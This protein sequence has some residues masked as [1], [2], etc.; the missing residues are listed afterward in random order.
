MKYSNIVTL[1]LSWII[2]IMTP[3]TATAQHFRHLGLNNGLSQPSVMCISQ[4]QLGRMWFGTREGIN[5]YDGATMQSFKGWV[6]DPVTG[7][8][9]WIGNNVESIVP[10]SMN[11]MVILIDKNIVK[12]E[13][14]SDRFIPVVSIGEV[15]ALAHFNGELSYLSN[16]S[17]YR[18]YTDGRHEFLFKTPRFNKVNDL[19][20]SGDKFFV[21]A[22]TGLWAFDKNSGHPTA[23]L[24]GM[25]V[26]SSFLSK[27]G[28]L[29]ICT[30]SNGVMCLRPDEQKPVLVSLPTPMKGAMGAHQTRRAVEDSFG[31]IWYGTFSGLHCYDPVT[32]TTKLIEAPHNLSGLSHSSIFGLYHDKDGTIWA[33]SYYGGVNYFNPGYD[34]YFNFDYTGVATNGLYHSLIIDMVYD[35]SGNLWMGTDGGG[36][37]CVNPEWR[38]L[39]QLN[40]M[41]GTNALRQNNIKALEYDPRHNRVY[42]GTHLGGLSYFDISSGRTVNLIDNHPSTALLG[43]VIQ[44]MKYHN[45]ALYVSSRKGITRLDTDTGATS[46]LSKDV[47][48]KFTIDSDG[49]LW[50]INNLHLTA[51]NVDGRQRPTL[52]NAIHQT[53]VDNATDIISTSHGITVGSRGKGLVH[54]DLTTGTARR[55]TT[56]NSPLP[57]DY[58]YTLSADSVGNIYIATDGDITKWNPADNTMRSISFD[59]FF[60]ESN[61]IEECGL[62]ARRDGSV[63]VGSTRGITVLFDKVFR[64]NQSTAT[65]STPTMFFTNLVVGSNEVRPNDGSGILSEALPYAKT[66]RLPHD[67][68]NFSV[69]VAQPDFSSAAAGGER[70]Q[71]RLDGIDKEWQT[72][73]GNNIHYT[74]LTPG[75]YT[76]YARPVSPAGEPGATT[77]ELK[78]KVSHAW[79]ASVWAWIVY[80]VIIVGIGSYIFRR[81]QIIARLRQSLHKEQLE[82]QQIEKL[83]QEKLVFFTNVSHEF[84]TPLTLI[85]SH[86]DMLLAKGGR[87]TPF[88]TQLSRIRAHAEQMS[89]LVTQLLEFRKFQSDS[90]VMRIGLHDAGALLNEVASPFLDYAQRRGIRFEVVVPDPSPRGCFDPQLLNRVLVNILSNA[91]KYTPDGGHIECSVTAIDGKVRFSF[92]DNGRGIPEEEIP[93]VFDRFYNGSADEINQKDLDFKSTGI[94]LAFAKSIV[95]KHHGTITVQSTEN[96]GSTFTVE[97]PTSREPFAN[98]PQVL[99]DD[100]ATTVTTTTD[101]LQIRLANTEE[102]VTPDDSPTPNKPLILIAEDNDELREQLSIFFGAYYRVMQAADGAEAISMAR[103]CNPDLI[104]SDVLM[105]NMN[106]VEMCRAIKSDTSMCHI[107]VILLTA[108]SGVETR[109]EGLNANAD[110]YVTKPYDSAILLA[111]ADNLLRNR[112]LLQKQFENKPISEIDISVV[113]PLDR[114]LLQRTSEII[115]ANL[116]DPDFDIPALCSE[117]AI[118]KSLFYNKFKSLTGLTPNAYILNYRLKHAAKLLET[119][120]HL[121]V[122]EI[123]DKTGFATA[124]YFSRCF[125]KQFGVA[126]RDYRPGE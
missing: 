111:R 20:V 49:N 18:L 27:N 47:P 59:R 65:R 33:G 70:F 38:V 32:Q 71:Y 75:T 23:M 7:N 14:R 97:I 22:D 61:L 89:H 108:L 53:V 6:K 50:Y 122:T 102:T 84:Q 103:T 114:D 8:D 95:D 98:D 28:S 96:V 19:C 115:E 45:G 107:P 42:I 26:T 21:S 24:E 55:L 76:L 87:H 104:I 123:A 37:C 44:H 3:F 9:V 118:S 39:R 99:F 46:Q 48:L 101:E 91:F 88:T 41:S 51:I 10:D 77:I 81:T 1:L 15:G 110:D 109:L 36:A 72:A 73:Q 4:D 100:S 68:N 119:Q 126:P 78:V 85:L 17:L 112:R 5:I 64:E 83:N 54:F 60:P 105:P 16:D 40:S 35:S 30:E 25:A 117:L 58:C 2:L 92:T 120:P 31:R 93:F 116:A 12:Y 63:L 67:R 11:N 82:R 121:S 57:S 86:I 62:L 29:W 69:T 43:N 79:Y 56:A 74:N 113:H 66:I 125:K 90:Q 106:G 94:G 80:L 52:G 34:P 124:V 13:M